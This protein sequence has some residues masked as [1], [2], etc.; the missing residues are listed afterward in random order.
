MTY[1]SV[2]QSCWLCAGTALHGTGA[3]A[4]PNR[5]AHPS[6]RGIVQPAWPGHALVNIVRDMHASYKMAKDKNSNHIHIKYIIPYP[7]SPI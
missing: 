2:F 3:G 7:L 5:R 1:G 6:E 4:P